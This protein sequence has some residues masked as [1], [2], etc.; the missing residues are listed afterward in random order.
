MLPEMRLHSADMRLMDSDAL[1]LEYKRNYGVACGNLDI[2]DLI[3]NPAASGECS[4]FGLS[5]KEELPYVIG[6]QT[7]SVGD[8]VSDTTLVTEERIKALP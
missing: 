3:N 7:R 2:S 1:A 6:R 5:L 8:D 4:V